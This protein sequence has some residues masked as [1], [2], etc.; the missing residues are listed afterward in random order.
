LSLPPSTFLAQSARKKGTRR[1]FH[2]AD[3]SDEEAEPVASSRRDP[4][5][6]HLDKPLD[7]K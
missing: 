4:R 1:R 6:D 7:S 3:V 2:G 5:R